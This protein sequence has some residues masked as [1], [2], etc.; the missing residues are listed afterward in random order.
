MT[1]L[2]FIVAVINTGLFA[3]IASVEQ[4]K[5][6]AEIKRFYA[7]SGGSAGARSLADMLTTAGYPLSRYRAGNLMT[8]LKLVSCQIPQ[9]N[10]KKSE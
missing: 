8:E 2:V 7:L 10:Y 6:R 1:C 5:L 3:I 9:H 4:I